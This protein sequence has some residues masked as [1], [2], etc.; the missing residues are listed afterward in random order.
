MMNEYNRLKEGYNKAVEKIEL[1][2]KDILEKRENEY[3]NKLKE[4]ENKNKSSNIKNK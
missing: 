2:M 4:I 1:Q 3:S